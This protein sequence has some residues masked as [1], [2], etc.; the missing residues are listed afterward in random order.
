MSN[1]CR[2]CE[3]PVYDSKILCFNCIQDLSIKEA[4]TKVLKKKN[5]VVKKNKWKTEWDKINGNWVLENF[6][7]Q[8]FY[9]A[10]ILYY[11]LAVIILLSIE[12]YFPTYILPD[13]A[14]LFTDILGDGLGETAFV[15]LVTGI[16]IIFYVILFTCLYR[17]FYFF[18][19][20]IK[21]KNNEVK[22]KKLTKKVAIAKLKEAKELLDLEVISKKE[23]NDLKKEL[24]PIINPK[25][26]LS[27][28]DSLS[29]N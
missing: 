7:F 19:Q 27:S 26:Q 9:T 22:S 13:I 6:K 3:S 29:K 28:S 20:R 1:F 8:N 18:K 23:Y 24:A 17:L 25:S 14:R 10:A 21:I 16:T 2:N 5:A 15:G 12:I 11:S 4:E